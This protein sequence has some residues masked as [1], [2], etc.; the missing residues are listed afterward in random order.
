MDAMKASN[1]ELLNEARA[2]RGKILKEAKEL[3]DSIVGE[4]QQKAKDEATRIIAD[5]RGDI[6]AQ[7][8]AAIEEVRKEVGAISIEI[9]QKLLQR[10]LDSEKG[11]EEYAK[12]LVDQIKLN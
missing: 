8:N 6:E 4:A 11:Q 9:A 3:R 12:S 1:E 2:E 5:A 10:E 7:K